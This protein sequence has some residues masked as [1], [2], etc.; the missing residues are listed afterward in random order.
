MPAAKEGEEN[1][2]DYNKVSTNVTLPAGKHIIRMTVTGAWF[3]IDYFTLVKGANATDPEP[4]V[5]TEAIADIR[6]DK[7]SL[8]DY[9]VFDQQGV[10][11]GVL[12]AYGFKAAAESLKASSAVKNSGIYY[13]RSR[14][15]GKMQAVRVIR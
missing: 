5:G 6:F 13:L 11:L 4:I 1:Y 2:D 7:N 8:Q 10:R 15:T 12:S 14:T 9:Y 3:D